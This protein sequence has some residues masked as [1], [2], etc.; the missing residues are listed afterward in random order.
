[1][2]GAFSA[3]VLISPFIVLLATLAMGG[4]PE[5]FFESSSV[6][7]VIV[8]TFAA[9]LASL[10]L[11][12]IRRV[13]TP[14]LRVIVDKRINMMEF[15]SFL[16]ELSISFRRDGLFGLE[17]VV[18]SRKVP[19]PGI[20]RAVQLAMEI[21]DIKQIREVL[22]IEK[23]TYLEDIDNAIN[24]MEILGT[25]APAFGLLGTVI[26]LVYMLANL[27]DPSTIGQGLALALLTTFYG[28][29]I[30]N[31]IFTP[32]ASRLRYL[33]SKEEVLLNLT[34]KAIIFMLDGLSPRIIRDSLVESLIGKNNS[35]TIKETKEESNEGRE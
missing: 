30:S 35:I 24:F 14:V 17:R 16:S 9:G 2:F 12:V 10:P 4:S 3:L 21:S 34:E 15:I 5:L 23:K 25:Y 29:I 6:L 11:D 7:F 1:M 13:L 22:E 31:M 28:L 26:G 27:K 33:R 8:G 20:K 18:N 19:Y 32:L